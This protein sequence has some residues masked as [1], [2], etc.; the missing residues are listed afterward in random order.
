MSI[1]IAKRIEKDI[2]KDICQVL[3][4]AFFLAMFAKIYIPLFFTP[5]PIILQNSIA[6]SYG[7]F[8]G[9]K[10][11]SIAT[12]LFIFL[13]SIG[14]PF[15]AGGS[16]GMQTV[17]G[18]TGGYI[19]SYFISCFVV[20]KIFQKNLDLS[21]RKIGLTML[22]GHLIVLFGGALWLSF[23]LGLK[24]AILLGIVPFIATDI[25]KSIVLTKLIHLKNNYF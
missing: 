3:F 14:L 19:L 9:A 20:G 8:L 7:F 6:I 21:Q 25:F 1:T 10:K 15:F 22:L 24:K 11:G 2:I 18:A 16:F 13:G 23:F 17:M 4:G 12:L 5:V